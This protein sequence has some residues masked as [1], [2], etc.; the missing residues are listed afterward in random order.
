ML[1][2]NPFHSAT[3]GVG[4]R[5]RSP[6]PKRES[7]VRISGT[8]PDALQ[9]W[10]IVERCPSCGS[11]RAR[12]R[13]ALPDRSY[14]FAGERIPLPDCGITVAGCDD[15]KLYYKSVVPRPAYLASIFRRHFDTSA[16]GKWL[17]H[18]DYS[19]EIS[20]LRDLSDTRHF[21]LIDIGAAGGGLLGQYAGGGAPAR[22]SALDVVR[23]PGLDE[24]L[25]GEF[26]TGFLDEPLQA[27]SGVP[28]DVATLFDVFEH[29]YDPGTAFANLR[30]LVRQDGLV[31]IETGDSASY[32]PRRFGIEQWWYAR[33]LE[34]HIFWCREALIDAAARHG[35]DVVFCREVRHK[36]RREMSAA[37]AGVDLLKV[38]LY[39]VARRAYPRLAAC[40]GKEGN[41]P[42]HPFVKD[43][44]QACLR[45]R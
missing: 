19:R 11:D 17:E 36:S 32:W 4:E 28:Y 1:L 27:W 8:T 3:T 34:H 12:A 10:R 2:E 20:L 33:L 44:L 23:H 45:M 15:C 13:G 39:R 9:A 6:T 7:S 29:L 42:W 35:F 41:Q 25:H 21:D 30:A 37:N 14:V 38:G 26:I 18:H 24:H 22:R 43:H 16:D 31:F 5:A 40:F